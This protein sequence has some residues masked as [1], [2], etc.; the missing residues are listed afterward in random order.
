M[1]SDPIGGPLLL[2]VILI[3]INAYFA[4]TEIAVLSLNDVKIRHQ[5][6]EGDR[7]A[8]L[9]MKLA[10]NPNRFLS[11]IQV[12]ITLAGF[13]GS[14]FAAENFASVLAG[15]I[16][17]AGV[18]VD[19]Q[20]LNTLCVIV[21]T[22]ILSYFTLVLGELVPK[23]IAM[24]QPE[25][26]ARMSCKFILALAAFFRPVV[27]LLSKS[28]NGV[29]RLLGMN[30][31]AEPEEVTEEEIRA[32]VDMGGE[33]GAIEENEKEMIENIF[34]FNNRTAEDVMTHRTDVTASMSTTAKK[35]LS[36]PFWTRD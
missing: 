1:S 10:E 5:A 3:A 18:T 19:P 30:P 12:G 13:L 4:S 36:L 7:V 9:L 21:V 33:S 24:Q 6:E 22:L 26:V 27:W 17:A 28:T 15:A 11:T 34:E 16:L 31:N 14:A 35:P 32:M 8:K 2:Q 20:L 25:R 29:L 23:R